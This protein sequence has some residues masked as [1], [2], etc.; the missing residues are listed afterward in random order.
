[1]KVL[2][3]TLISFMIGM[4][5][6]LVCTKSDAAICMT[7][8]TDGQ[9]AFLY[10]PDA[11]TGKITPTAY[12]FAATAT[13]N[14]CKITSV[15]VRNTVTETYVI[16]NPQNACEKSAVLACE[17][18]FGGLPICT[19]NNFANFCG[20]C[21]VTTKPSNGMGD[22]TIRYINGQV[23]DGS[24]TANDISSCPNTQLIN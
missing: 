7:Q 5:F 16:P 17:P 10:E 11:K 8:T 23:Y 20:F 14:Q 12:V 21:L 3:A 6:A 9:T 24:K 19:T 13:M 1:M 22:V 2:F 15:T 18:S 4:L